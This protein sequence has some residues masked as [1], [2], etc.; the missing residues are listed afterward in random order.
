[1]NIVILI[2]VMFLSVFCVLQVVYRANENRE[3]GLTPDGVPL[4]RFGQFVR[5]ALDAPFNHGSRTVMPMDYDPTTVEGMVVRINNDM[6]ML[7]MDEHNES[8]RCLIVGYVPIDTPAWYTGEEP[9]EEDFAGEALD[10]SP[11]IVWPQSDQ[12]H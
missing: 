12:I 9:R 7:V 3:A 4:P 5:A 6:T 10:P 8:H 11:N 2:G 1:M